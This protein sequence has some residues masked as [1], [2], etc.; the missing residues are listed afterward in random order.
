LQ[1]RLIASVI[2]F[3][4]S[5]F[6][7]SLI[8]LAQ[9]FRYDFL[10]KELCLDVWKSNC[11]I[12]T[13]N[14]YFSIS[15]FILCLICFGTSILALKLAKPNKTIVTI[16]VKPIPAELM[17]YTLPYVVSFMSLNYQDTGKFVGVIIF[18][19]WMFII[20]HRSGQIILNPLFIVFGWQLNEVKYSYLGDKK[21]YTGRVLAN[22]DI[23][24]GRELNVISVQNVMIG[25]SAPEPKGD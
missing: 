20:T 21:T 7:L 10:T 1:P 5:Y 11:V 18:L 22:N 17:S 6:P 16:E 2:I 14:P 12:P 25:Q 8:L 24:T 4:G 19:V 23:V 13:Q 3:L 15:I 9:D